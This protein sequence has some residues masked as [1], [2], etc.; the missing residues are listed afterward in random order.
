MA[1]RQLVFFV[2]SETQCCRAGVVG[3][4]DFEPIMR[5]PC[6]NALLCVCG[7]TRRAHSENRR[8]PRRGE[9]RD[10]IDLMAAACGL[11]LCDKLGN[12]I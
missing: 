1:P 2:P 3:I 4:L 5:S 11:F 7:V 12:I 6:A 10:A 9:L 8:T